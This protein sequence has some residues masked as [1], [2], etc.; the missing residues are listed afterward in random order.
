MSQYGLTVDIYL[1]EVPRSSNESCINSQTAYPF[2]F[3]IT[4]ITIKKYNSTIIS[5]ETGAT[6]SRE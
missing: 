6:N 2:K 3:I 5:A 4:Q 1:M